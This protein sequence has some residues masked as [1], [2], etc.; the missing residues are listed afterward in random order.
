M[1]SL[2][3]PSISHFCRDIEPQR[4]WDHDLDFLGSHDV[5]GHMTIGWAMYGFLKV[6]L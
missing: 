6:V 1:V 4:F 3:Q 2:N 5:I